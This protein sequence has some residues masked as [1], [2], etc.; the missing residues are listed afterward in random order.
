[1]FGGLSGLLIVIGGFLEVIYGFLFVLG[2]VEYC[3]E[4]FRG[5][6]PPVIVVCLYRKF[7]GT[8]GRHYGVGEPAFHIVG[9]PFVVQCPHLIIGGI[10][11]G[12]V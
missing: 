3:S 5:L 7:A 4:E 9:Y 10:V 12:I 8:C 11:L 6:R 2:I 1:M